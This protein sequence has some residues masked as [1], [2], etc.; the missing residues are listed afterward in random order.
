VYDNYG[1]V[2]PDFWG[3][4]FPSIVSGLV[5]FIPVVGTVASTAMDVGLDILKNS[6]TEE[7]GKDLQDVNYDVLQQDTVNQLQDF[8]RALQQSQQQQEQV[9]NQLL[10][11]EQERQQIENTL[12]G[13][14]SRSEATALRGTGKDGYDLHA[15]IIKGLNTEEAQKI[16]RDYIKNKKRKFSRITK[17]GSMRF[18]NVPKTKFIKKSFRT[19]IINP[20]VSLVYGKLK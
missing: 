1:K 11:Y 7:K 9:N 15:V 8:D 19:K 10:S 16:A 13:A 5:S 2:E 4:V 20:N 14:S 17:S 12:S 6:Q 18:R 3:D